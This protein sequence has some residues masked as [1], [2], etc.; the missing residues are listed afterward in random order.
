MDGGRHGYPRVQAFKHRP[1]FLRRPDLIKSD[2]IRRQGTQS[3]LYPL[4]FWKAG[5]YIRT[6]AKIVLR[7][8]MIN[9]SQFSPFV[10]HRDF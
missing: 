4:C 9:R 1:G 8:A 5:Q 2:H 7:P 6:M 10:D 3:D